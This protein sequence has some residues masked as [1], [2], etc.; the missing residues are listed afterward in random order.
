MSFIKQ[1]ERAARGSGG[2][3]DL[4]D[5]HRFGLIFWLKISNL[6]IYFFGGG[7]GGGGGWRGSEN[8][9]IFWGVDFFGG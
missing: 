7:G 8:M 5:Q 3:F 6:F 4:F 9:T 2:Y 1:R